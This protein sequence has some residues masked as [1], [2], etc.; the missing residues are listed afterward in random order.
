[1]PQSALRALDQSY[2]M[3]IGQGPAPARVPRTRGQ[4]AA[5]MLGA[6]AIGT[7]PIP[8]VGDIVGAAADV[9]MY[10]SDPTT[11]TLPNYLLSGVGVLPWITGAAGAKAIRDAAGT[12]LNGCRVQRASP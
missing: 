1:M 9:A 3:G 10:A 8:I 7:T 2:M 12:K 4:T 5:D 11:R 6:A